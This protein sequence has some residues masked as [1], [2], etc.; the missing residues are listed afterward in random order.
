MADTEINPDTTESQDCPNCPGLNIYWTNGVCSICGHP[1]PTESQATDKPMTENILNKVV[2]SGDTTEYD[3]AVRIHE[4]V[5]GKMRTMGYGLL[6]D[7]ETFYELGYE[8]F[9][10]S[11]SWSDFIFTMHQ[12]YSICQ[13]AEK[14]QEVREFDHAKMPNKKSLGT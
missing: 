4:A 3:E 6:L 5:I 11:E 13:A 8:L 10:G 9:Y 12:A 1:K 2:N 14:W 7:G